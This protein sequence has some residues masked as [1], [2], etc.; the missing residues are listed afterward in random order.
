MD[1]IDAKELWRYIPPEEKIDLLNRSHG[2]GILAALIAIIVAGTCA[3]GLQL[4]W[5]LWGSF[6]TAPLV[7][8][9]A[10][11]R[12]WRDLKPRLMLEYLAARSCARR[13][14]F[15]QNSRTLTAELIF[16]GTAKEQVAADPLAEVLATL[17]QSDQEEAVWIALFSDVVIVMVERPG[18]ARLKFGCTID[19]TLEIRAESPDGDGEYSNERVLYLTYPEKKGLKK[20][21]C[22]S[23]KH[24]A[25]LII[26]E[27]RLQYFKNPPKISLAEEIPDFV[28]DKHMLAEPA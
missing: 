11:G 10:A 20:T 19:D 15:V 4:T 1:L 27:K 25:S 13:L 21:F 26:F 6:L 24:P 9:F 16:R 18:G 7:F 12:A 3:V 2:Q 17:D 8:Q 5:L 28:D 14:A 23:S 22:L